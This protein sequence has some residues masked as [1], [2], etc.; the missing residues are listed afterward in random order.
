M[1]VEN[2]TSPVIWEICKRQVIVKNGTCQVVAEYG[3]IHCGELYE[4]YH[5]G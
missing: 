3:K 2:C 4:P 5:C 1:S